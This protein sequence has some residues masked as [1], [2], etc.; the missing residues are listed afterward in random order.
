MHRISVEAFR[1]FVRREEDSVSPS[2]PRA[3]ATLREEHRSILAV[4]E[5]M[6]R[7]VKE[8]RA[9]RR[10]VDPRVFRAMLYYLDTFSG[11]IHHPKEDQYLFPAIRER[12]AEAGALIAELEDD[13]A[14][15]EEALRRL[16]QALIH[17]EEGGAAE[18]SRFEREVESFTRNCRDHI[19]REEE[20]L[21]PLACKAIAAADWAMLGIAIARDRDPLLMGRDPGDFDRLLERIRQMAPI[22]LP[23]DSSRT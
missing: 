20:L 5:G 1:P 18:F 2:L 10:T 13:H 6:G 23:N 3:L 14:R 19:R 12:S 11:S 4:V 22:W 15:G 16:A 8:R 9:L 7:L 17:Y 21:F